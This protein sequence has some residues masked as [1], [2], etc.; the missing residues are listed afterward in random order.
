[1]SVGSIEALDICILIWLSRLDVVELDAVVSAPVREDLRDV[2]WPVVDPYC[3][4]FTSPLDEPVQR[5][6]DPA[7]RDRSINNDI[8]RLTHAFIEYVQGAE[9]DVSCVVAG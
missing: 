2:L 9:A 8:Q 3:I 1:M 5:P 7:A 4:P 6:Y